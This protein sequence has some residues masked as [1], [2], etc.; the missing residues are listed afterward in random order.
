MRTLLLVAV[1]CTLVPAGLGAAFR[2]GTIKWMRTSG[3]PGLDVTFFVKAFYDFDYFGT[4]P[5]TNVLGNLGTAVNLDFVFNF[6]DNTTQALTT[7]YCGISNFAI[8]DTLEVTCKFSHT[9][10]V[11]QTYTPYYTVTRPSLLK[12][13]ANKALRV[14]ATIVLSA[15]AVNNPP[16]TAVLPNQRI[17][18]VQTVT[19]YSWQMTAFDPEGEAVT[20][21][22]TTPTQLGDTTASYPDGLTVSSSGLVTWTTLN[23]SGVTAAGGSVPNFNSFMISVQVTDAS[24]NMVQVDWNLLLA[25]TTSTKTAAVMSGNSASGTTFN[26]LTNQTGNSVTFSVTAN[27]AGGFLISA[28]TFAGS[29]DNISPTVNWGATINVPF[30]ISFTWTPT[31]TG[32]HTMCFSA[33]T[34]T[35]TSFSPID[36]A[37]VTESSPVCYHLTATLP[38]PRDCSGR[39]VCRNLYGIC[40]CNSG[41]CFSDCSANF[42][43]PAYANGCL[44]LALTKNVRG[45]VTGTNLEYQFPASTTLGTELWVTLPTGMTTKQSPDAM[46]ALDPV[47]VQNVYGISPAVNPTSVVLENNV[48]QLRW[49]QPI[50]ASGLVQFTLTNLQLPNNCKPMRWSVAG[51]NCTQQDLYGAGTVFKRVCT[52]VPGATLTIT[53]TPSFTCNLCNACRAWQNCPDGSP[54]YTCEHEDVKYT[55]CGDLSTASTPCSLS[56]V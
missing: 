3:Q 30:T 48:V 4:V 14:Q 17:T 34:A 8:K 6:G 13:N 52:A 7:T 25:R 2:G 24:G 26:V 1:L 50:Q 43:D 16:T 44:G 10:P 22:L 27:A 11:Y 35:L 19:T 45:A 56:G 49:G 36:A 5:I 42:T 33:V 15:T 23:S 39:G 41:T 9:Y 38:C 37:I 46:I 28:V 12:N 51:W 53:H 32:Y 29:P 40:K 55:R 54:G 21:A 18:V 31:T 20:F 47:G